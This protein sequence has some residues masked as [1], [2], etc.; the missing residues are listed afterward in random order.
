MAEKPIM[1]ATLLSGT[2]P[3]MG[4]WGTPIPSVTG[5]TTRGWFRGIFMGGMR[6]SRILSCLMSVIRGAWCLIRGR[7]ISRTKG[8]DMSFMVNSITPGFHPPLSG[9]APRPDNKSWLRGQVKGNRCNGLTAD[10]AD[11]STDYSACNV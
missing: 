3:A 11:F 9:E 7:G 10:E 1:P 6:I 5:E 4:I 8:L 2:G